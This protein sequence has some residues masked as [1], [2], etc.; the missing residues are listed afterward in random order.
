[1]P[2]WVIAMVGALL[3]W[4][5]WGVF[6]NL[7]TR[8]VNATSSLIWEVAG[9]A[10]VGVLVLSITAQQRQF[11]NDPRGMLFG[12]LTGVTYTIGLLLAFVALRSANAASGGLESG[13]VH[14]VLVVT[15]L[16]PLVAGIF[17]YLLLSEPLSGRQMVG[18]GLGVVAIAIFMSEPV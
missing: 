3:V 6:F 8:Y 11:E 13:K 14:T 15:A 17:N 9:A 4:G 10:I 12:I 16:Y 18:M 2:F 7:T 5:L 1:M